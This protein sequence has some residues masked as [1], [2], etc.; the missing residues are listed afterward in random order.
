MNA[1]KGLSGD[2]S[3]DK[4]D[5]GQG[6]LMGRVLTFADDYTASQR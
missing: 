1:E 4:A 6:S 3:G 5:A 2:F